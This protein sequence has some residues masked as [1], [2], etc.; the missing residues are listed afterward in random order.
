MKMDRIVD[1]ENEIH[2]PWVTVR[3]FGMGR[4]PSAMGL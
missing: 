3:I 4:N 2:G 1:D